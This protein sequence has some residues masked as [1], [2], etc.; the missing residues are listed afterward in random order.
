M[1]DAFA[2]NGIMVHAYLMYGFPTQTT[3]ETVDSL[4]VVRQLFLNGCIHSAYWHKF[5][6]TIH[7]PIG[8]NPQDFNIKIV[9]PKFEGFAQNDLWH[10]DPLGT[11]HDD[12][13]EG[14][15]EALISFL[16]GLG[17]DVPLQEW[18]DI[19]IPETTLDSELIASFLDSE[20]L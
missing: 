3:Q 12:F 10:E 11:N 1:T 14:L 19:E 5:T 2:Q 18:F 17:L 9:G 15:N 20:N 4:E 8:M 7:S 6:T 13:T 16:N